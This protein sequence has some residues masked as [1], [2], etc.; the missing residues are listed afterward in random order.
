MLY[1]KPVRRLIHHLVSIYNY[2]L[3]LRKPHMKTGI[4]LLIISCLILLTGCVSHLT[5]NELE[6]IRSVGVI[7]EFPENP[8][9]TIIGTTIFNNSHDE[10]K[11]PSIKKLISTEVISKIKSRGYTVT[12]I[13][14]QKLAKEFDLIIVIIPRDIYGM[15]ATNGYG[16]YRRAMLNVKAFEGTYVALNL[17]PKKNGRSRCDT[18]FGKSLTAL[19]I[20][21]PTEKWSE[22]DDSDKVKIIESLR[23]GIK[24]AVESAFE[25]TGF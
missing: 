19:T 12:E 24:I 21:E 9:L 13:S 7:N 4:N 25:N 1:T 14:D 20:A 23:H 2:A 10:V 18:C 16:F 8:N 3:K 15:P 11:D 22:I 17:M 5:T 6:E